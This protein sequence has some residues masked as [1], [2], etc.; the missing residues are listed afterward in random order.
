ME[1]SDIQVEFI[2]YIDGDL[3][4]E[5]RLRVELHTAECYACREQLD[6]LG[7]LLEVCGA[8]MEHPCPVDRFDE[9]KGRL[10]SEE[11]ELT[12]VPRR[13]ALRRREM[14]NKLA[15]AAIVIAM[16]AAS[17]FLVRGAKRLFSPLDG[18][19]TLGNGTGVDLPFRLPLIEQR[20][21]FQEEVTEWAVT[22]TG[23]RDDT[24]S[25]TAGP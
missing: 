18:T 2:G 3:S 25:P 20:L 14:R 7:R 13:P 8:V 21:K 4:E 17:P 12:S 15:V 19:A 9:L 23:G 5:D 22:A 11:P 6:E 24:D 10:A 16:I 1:C